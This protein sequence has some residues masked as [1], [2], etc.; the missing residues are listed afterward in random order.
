MRS[1]EL[2]VKK[3]SALSKHYL[4]RMILHKFL[5]ILQVPLCL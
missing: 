1:T 3:I 5:D 2:G 4:L